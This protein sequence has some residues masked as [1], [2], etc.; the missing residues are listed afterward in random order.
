GELRGRGFYSRYFLIPK[1][2]GGLRPILDLRGLNKFMVKLKFRM[3]S[4]G[5][6]IPSMDPGDWYAALDMKDAYF[7]IAIYSPHR[8]FL[9]FVVGQRHFQF[10]VLP[11]GLSTAP[12]VFTKCMAVVAA[13]L[14][15]QSVQVFPYL[16]DWLIRGNSGSQ[17]QSHIWTAL[18]MFKQLGLL[19]NVEKSTLAPTQ[20]LDFIGAVLDSTLARA[21]LPEARFQALIAI[22][23]GLQS[24]PTSTARCCLSLLGHMAS[25]TFVTAHA[26]LRLQPLQAWLSSVCQPRRDSLNLILT[27]PSQVLA[28]L[29]WWLDPRKVLE[30]LPFHPPQ[31]SLAL[32]TDASSLGWGA[33]LKGL[34]T[35]GLWSEQELTL[36]INVREL[37][38]VRLPCQ[39]FAQHLQGRC[40][41]ILTDNTTAI[42][43][44]QARRGTLLPAL[45]RSDTPVGLLH[46]PLHSPGC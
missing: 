28:S 19:L 40:V 14:R 11:F 38:A 24:F 8:R 17:V 33:H 41:A 10:T 18:S 31:P 6:I 2:K 12:R 26:R 21:F 9:R 46:S 4:L 30:G 20:R 16:N 5:T 7:H 23:R 27:V 13:A 42:L 45:P 35:Q 3:L 44:Q 34:Q 37:R 39:A 43:H 29:N 25:C 15:R 1:S 22:I 36:H 32:T